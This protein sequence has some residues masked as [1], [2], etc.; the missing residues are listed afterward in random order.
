ML[1]E[2]NCSTLVEIIDAIFDE[3]IYEDIIAHA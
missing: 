2:T 3:E 1:E